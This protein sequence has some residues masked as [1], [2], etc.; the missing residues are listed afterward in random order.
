M[1]IYGLGLFNGA[2]FGHYSSF[3][4][5]SS[6]LKWLVSHTNIMHARTKKDMQI[7][8]RNRIHIPN[9]QTERQTLTNTHIYDTVNH[10][11]PELMLT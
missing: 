7:H 5:F 1:D 9:G 10:D 8:A 11:I 4:I 3:L 2:G 6:G